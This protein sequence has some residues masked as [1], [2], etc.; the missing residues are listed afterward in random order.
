MSS[1]TTFL[2]SDLHDYLIRVSLRE[3]SIMKALRQETAA[4]PGNL[5]MISPEQGQLLALLATLI[6]AKNTID[7]GTYTGYSALSVAQALPA[8]ARIITCDIDNNVTPIAKRYFEKAGVADKI[9]LRLGPALA[10]LDTLINANQSGHF[11][12]VF[13]DADKQNYSHYYE[14]SLVL[15]RSGGLVV[16][17]NVLWKGRVIDESDQTTATQA[18]RQFNEAL[19][20]D[21]RIDLT[22][23]PLGDG[24]TI[25]RKK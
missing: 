7:I 25:A 21:E 2:T 9:E 19:A 8:D 1:E 14:K 18:I 3:N 24:M 10:T 16:I 5:M 15:L 13:I 23:I 12:F 20:H 17:D 6:N 22:I 11:D 4:L